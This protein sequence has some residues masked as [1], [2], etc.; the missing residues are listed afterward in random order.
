MAAPLELRDRLLT[1]RRAADT[2]FFTEDWRRLGPALGDH[3]R[4]V[5]RRPAARSPA[6]VLA[7][8]LPTTVRVG[9]GERIRLDKLQTGEVRVA[10]RPLVLIRRPG[11][12]RI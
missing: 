11:C 2:A 1:V 12:G 5:R 8:L 10:P 3:A 7:E 9:P 6:D 4:E